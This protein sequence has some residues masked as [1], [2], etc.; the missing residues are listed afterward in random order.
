MGSLGPTQLMFL[1]V[2]VAIVGAICGFVAAAVTRRNKRRA[3]RLFL[4]G[5]VCGLMT[6]AIVRERRRVTG[7]FVVRRLASAAPSVRSGLSPAHWYR[8][9]T[10]RIA[11][12][13]SARK[14]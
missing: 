4:L 9:L 11:I 6:G 12:N 3:R 14:C 2:A 5:F 13:P 1:L 10:Q 7:R 8:Q